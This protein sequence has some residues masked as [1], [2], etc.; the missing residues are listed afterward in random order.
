[1][2]VLEKPNLSTTDYQTILAAARVVC[3]SY[4]NYFPVYDLEYESAINYAISRAANTHTIR[5]G[6]RSLLSLAVLYAIRQCGH[7]RAM[8][9][10]WRK[11]DQA[12]ASRGRLQASAETPIPL[13]DFELLSF[14]ACH[15]RRRAAVLL[16]MRPERLRRKLDD[17]AFR[18][19]RG[20][21][22]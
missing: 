22:S 13:T 17:I 16:A 4:P 21:D 12:G 8:L 3:S 15:G 14:V 10:R 2:K 5:P 11:Q 20:L 7:A 1:M 19:V 6:G 9:E 18:V